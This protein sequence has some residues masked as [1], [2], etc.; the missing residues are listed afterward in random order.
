MRPP[1]LKREQ[2]NVVE[3]IVAIAELVQRD[4]RYDRNL[5]A[6][7]A[8]MGATQSNVAF[9][10]GAFLGLLCEIRELPATALAAE[11]SG[12]AKAAPEQMVAAGDL[13]DGMLAVSR[14]SVMLGADDLVAAVDELLEAAE[15][16]PFLMMLPRLR[17]A[18]ERLAESQRDS[19]AHTVA[20]RYGLA[21]S[22][23]VSAMPSGLAATAL[24]TRLDA[25]VARTLANWTL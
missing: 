22:D 3:G 20:Q 12:L 7:G 1:L 5:F 8:R 16:D 25:A 13:L 6:E 23:E 15:W 2:D 24:V 21:S 17:G 11:V 10:R 14:T 9:L 4:D 19:F 18:F